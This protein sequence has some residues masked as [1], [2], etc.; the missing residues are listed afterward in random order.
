MIAPLRLAL[1]AA[2]ALVAAAAPA[3][4]A[5]PR[6]PASTRITVNMVEYEFHLSKK[7]VPRGTVV[8][9]TAQ[10]IGGPVQPPVPG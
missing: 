10:V 8:E 4:T 3:G 1:A 7:R 6:S 2:A 5:A 9:T